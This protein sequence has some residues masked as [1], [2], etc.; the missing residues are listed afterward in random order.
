MTTAVER[1]H[2]GQLLAQLARLAQAELF[3]RLAA[4]GLSPA[5]V[6]PMHVTASIEADGSRLSELAAGA[7][8]TLPAMSELVDDLERL[9]MVER[10]PDPS[11]GRAKLIV[12]TEAGW[13]AKRTALR[14][15][16]EI[17]AEF[18]Q[19]VGPNRFE[20]AARTLDHLLRSLDG[21]SRNGQAHPPHRN[22]TS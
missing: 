9:G 12:L 4:A 16:G 14:V 19:R 7:R 6:A 21:A 2:I 10:R 15:I 13:E 20:A 3:A 18:A 8:M 22:G 11:D 17:E 5:G 1:D